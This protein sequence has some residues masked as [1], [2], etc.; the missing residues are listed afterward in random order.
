VERCLACE[1]EGSP[2]L[3]RGAAFARSKLTACD[4]SPAFIWL[5]RVTSRRLP[6]TSLGIADGLD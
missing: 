3:W 5:N 4:R 6:E 2:P 1:A